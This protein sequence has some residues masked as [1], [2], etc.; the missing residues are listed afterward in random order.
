MT[1]SVR[2]SPPWAN[3]DGSPHFSSVASVATALVGN[4]G[5]NR[6][7]I[8]LYRMLNWSYDGGPYDA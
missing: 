6:K 1:F 2:C 5:Q 7:V 8:L 4:A 3:G